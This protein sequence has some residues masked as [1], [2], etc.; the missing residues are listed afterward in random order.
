MFL[1][2][3][4]Y[5]DLKQKIQPVLVSSDT[6]SKDNYRFDLVDKFL[7]NL[8]KYEKFYYGLFRIRKNGRKNH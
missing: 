2:V 7:V 3:F 1:Y 8:R 4:K 5:P 6:K